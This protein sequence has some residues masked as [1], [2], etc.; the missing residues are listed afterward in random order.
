ME[1]FSDGLVI[2]FLSIWRFGY[3]FLSIWKGL[4]IWK[5]FGRVWNGFLGFAG[6]SVHLEG[7][8]GL[9]ERWDW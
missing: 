5:E 3:F 1:G 6:V 7:L 8:E 4:V 2:F 9:C